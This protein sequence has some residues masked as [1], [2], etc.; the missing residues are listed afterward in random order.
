MAAKIDGHIENLAGDHPGQLA[1]GLA[2]LVVQAAQSTPAGA[3]VVVLDKGL[4]QPRGGK[5]AGM[6]G[7]HE[8]AAFITEDIRLDEHHVRNAGGGKFHNSLFPMPKSL[9]TI[10]RRYCP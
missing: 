8:E 6:P 5:L 7:F 9:F 4:R 1:L 10:C 3:A 2:E